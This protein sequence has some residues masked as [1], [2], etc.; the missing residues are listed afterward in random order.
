LKNPRYDNIVPGGKN[1][2]HGGFM[3]RA[4]I[5]HFAIHILGCGCDN[6]VFNSIEEKENVLLACGT[7]LKRKIIVG[8][9]LL[10]YIVDAGALKPEDVGKVISEGMAERDSMGYNRLRLAIVSPEVSKDAS[11]YLCS[12]G[13]LTGKDEKTHIH[14]ISQEDAI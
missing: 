4:D 5:I 7:R 13:K 6:S 9:R 11:A 10:I 14:V 8:K 3:N 2:R 12:F 1:P